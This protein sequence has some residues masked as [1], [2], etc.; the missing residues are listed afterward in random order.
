[1]AY[2]VIIQPFIVSGPCKELRKIARKILFLPFLTRVCTC[3]GKET[4][5]GTRKVA[6]KGFG[7]V[8]CLAVPALPFPFPSGSVIGSVRFGS[9]LVWSRPRPCFGFGFGPRPR[10][11]PDLVGFGFRFRPSP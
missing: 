10:P 4:G 9:G 7:P 1:M 5:K 6:G 2:S 3:E 8:P 11:R